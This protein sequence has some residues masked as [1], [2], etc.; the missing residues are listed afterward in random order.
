MRA[1]SAGSG[2][3][4]VGSL[5]VAG[6]GLIRTSAGERSLKSG[7]I[8]FSQNPTVEQVSGLESGLRVVAISLPSPGKAVLGNT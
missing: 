4:A 2:G 8:T 1:G 3:D 7:R 5:M 6:G